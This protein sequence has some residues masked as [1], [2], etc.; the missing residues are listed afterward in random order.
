MK[1]RKHYISLT[2]KGSNAWHHHGKRQKLTERIVNIGET[3]DCDVRYEAGDW[4][5]EYYATIIKNEDS[6]GW[7]IVRRSSFIDVDIAGNGGFGYVHQLK[8][9]DIIRKQQYK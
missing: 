7:R 5:P 8:D 1:E 3:A 4:Q 6:E 2:F 9:G